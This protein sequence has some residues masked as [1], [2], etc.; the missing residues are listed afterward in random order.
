MTGFSRL[1]ILTSSTLAIGLTVPLTASAAEMTM[2]IQADTVLGVQCVQ[3]NQFKHNDPIV[4]RARVLN[5]ATGEPMAAD[6]LTSVVVQLPDGTNL[7]AHY[8]DHPPQKSTDSF[9]SVRWPVPKDYPTG[10]F[11]YKI[12]AT[13]KDGKTTTYEPFKVAT[14]QLTIAAN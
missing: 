13:S 2:A 3:S 6:A 1:L 12:V 4:W 5:T 9:W 7:Q 8:G 11:T 10:T 14:S